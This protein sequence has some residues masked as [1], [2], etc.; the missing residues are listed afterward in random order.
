MYLDVV[1]HRPDGGTVTI[2]YFQLVQWRGAL[3]M[4]EAGLKT[5]GGSVAA[6]IR[7]RFGLRPRFPRKDIL[8]F[9]CSVIDEVKASMD[10]G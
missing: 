2:P 1:M 8:A 10:E 6:H 4:E 7:K 9:V 3:R 5:R